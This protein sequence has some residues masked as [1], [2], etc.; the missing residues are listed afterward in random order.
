MWV[1]FGYYHPAE[2]KQRK[3]LHSYTRN[4]LLSQSILTLDWLFLCQRLI[5]AYARYFHAPFH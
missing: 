1:Q 3:Y 5:R 2:N 4:H